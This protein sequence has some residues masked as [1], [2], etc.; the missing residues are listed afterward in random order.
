LEIEMR[1]VRNRLNRFLRGHEQKYLDEIPALRA[2]TRELLEKAKRLA[3]TPEE[4][5]LVARIDD[6]CR[7]FFSETDRL[8]EPMA[9]GEQLEEVGLL[10]DRLMQKEI[11]TPARE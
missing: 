11:F 6:G 4:Q 10:V 2:R 9:R 1:E 8:A 5:E 3:S 7:H